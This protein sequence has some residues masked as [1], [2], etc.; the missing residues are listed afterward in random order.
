MEIKA[1]PN[2]SKRIFTIRKYRDGK[3]YTKYRTIQ[4]SKSEFEDL[5]SNTTE[6]WRDFLKTQYAYFVI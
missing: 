4:F 6:D 1:T 2:Q 5:E 3:V